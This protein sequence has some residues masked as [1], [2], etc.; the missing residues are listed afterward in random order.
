V[1]NDTK[2]GASERAKFH[3][4]NRKLDGPSETI[5]VIEAADKTKPALKDAFLKEIYYPPASKILM[6][7]N[8]LVRERAAG[9]GK[10]VTIMQLEKR[11][12]GYNSTMVWSDAG[13]ADSFDDATHYYVPLSGYTSLGKVSDVKILH[14]HLNDS[15][16]FT[17]TIYGVRKADMDFIKT[18]PNWVNVDVMVAERLTKL[19]HSDVM[20]LVKQALDLKEFFEYNVISRIKKD[21]PYKLMYD[22]FKDVKV[23]DVVQRSSLVFLCNTYQVKT[24]ANIDP[25]VLITKYKEEVH[26]LRQRYPLMK[27]LTKYTVIDSDLA[28]YINLIDESKGI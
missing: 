28:E 21:S 7:S 22:T 19:G 24:Q 26:Q 10:N 15:K 27:S 13:K 14:E 25:S 8:L 23:A 5:Y 6:A 11:N 16:V 20:S 12:R 2:T 9:M 3:W 18:Q 1:F 17:G 4:K